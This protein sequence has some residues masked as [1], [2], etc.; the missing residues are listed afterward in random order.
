MQLNATIIGC[1]ANHLPVLV[2]GCECLSLLHPPF[3]RRP[4]PPCPLLPDRARHGVELAELLKKECGGHYEEVML[5][6][7]QGPLAFDVALLEKAI[8]GA[9]TDEELLTELVIGR[10]PLALDML[11]AAFTAKTHRKFDDG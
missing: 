3:A 5:A 1:P 7:I 4:D 9:G 8:V 10:T 6:R 11:K 2:H